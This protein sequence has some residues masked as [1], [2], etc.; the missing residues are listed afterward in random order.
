MEFRA[1]N[2]IQEVSFDKGHE[3]PKSETIDIGENVLG[4]LMSIIVK[5][6]SDGK[7]VRVKIR[8]D[9]KVNE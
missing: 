8:E 9:K 2:Y 1:N 7:I 5:R 6:T 4:E 3:E